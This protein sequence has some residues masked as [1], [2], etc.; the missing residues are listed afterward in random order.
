[1]K[2]KPNEGAGLYTTKSRFQS[3]QR[4]SVNSVPPEP[5][6]GARLCSV[7]PGCAGPCPQLRPLAGPQ[8][9]DF[10]LKGCLGRGCAGP[11]PTPAPGGA[12]GQGFFQS[13]W[14][15]PKP[16]E[17]ADARLPGNIFCT[18][19]RDRRQD[20]RLSA[21][22]AGSL[23]PRGVTPTPRRASKRKSDKYHFSRRASKRKSDK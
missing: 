2:G 4:D 7:L 10:C 1:M 12:A 17:L 3:V 11:C 9:R 18:L 19:S 14:G 5:R 21:L 22:R 8:S 6:S 15:S 20:S 16:P 13:V 23:T